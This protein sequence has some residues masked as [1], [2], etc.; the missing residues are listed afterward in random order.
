MASSDRDVLPNSN[1]HS[2][3][4]FQIRHYH[5]SIKAALNAGKK[6]AMTLTWFA[7][8]AMKSL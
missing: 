1:R 8:A 3:D 6:G 7:A 2:P 5:Q 4:G